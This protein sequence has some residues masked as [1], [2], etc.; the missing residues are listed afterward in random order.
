MFWRILLLLLRILVCRLI[1]LLLR[2]ELVLTVVD[3][4]LILLL[5][6]IFI[7]LLLQTII[8]L[9]SNQLKGQEEGAKNLN[10]LKT[11]LTL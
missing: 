10:L 8:L 7:L 11:Y 1:E 4:L 9:T 2:I 6:R 5:S 3:S